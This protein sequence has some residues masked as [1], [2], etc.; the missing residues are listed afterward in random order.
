MVSKK[1]EDGGDELALPY[2]ETF[3]WAFDEWG[4][5]WAVLHEGVFCKRWED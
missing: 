2:L 1:E 5:W 4:A 3:F